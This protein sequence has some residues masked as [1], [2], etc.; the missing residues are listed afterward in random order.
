MLPLGRQAKVSQMGDNND[1]IIKCTSYE[2]YWKHQPIPV[3]DQKHK[4]VRF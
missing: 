4:N 3:I 1:G 2:K